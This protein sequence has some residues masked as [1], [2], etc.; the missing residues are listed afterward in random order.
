[1]KRY[2]GELKLLLL[3]E[4]GQYLQASGYDRR[5][6]MSQQHIE[7]VFKALPLYDTEREDLALSVLTTLTQTAHHLLCRLSFLVPALG[8]SLS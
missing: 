6:L 7:L 4:I 5:S 8:Q 2:F 3:H 1:M